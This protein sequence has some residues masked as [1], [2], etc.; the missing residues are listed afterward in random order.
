MDLKS[1]LVFTTINIPSIVVDYCNNFER[2][3]HKKEIGIII[4]GDKK[5]PDTEAFKIYRNT[6]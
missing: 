4:I 2:F 6:I 1:Y 3:G 5:T